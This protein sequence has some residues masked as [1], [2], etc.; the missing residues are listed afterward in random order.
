[1][2]AAEEA[3]ASRAE[4]G[5]RPSLALRRLA[6]R[7]GGECSSPALSH[8]VVALWHGSHRPLPWGRGAK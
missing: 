3:W 6:S 2:P 5:G 7:T 4:G 8:P 1:M